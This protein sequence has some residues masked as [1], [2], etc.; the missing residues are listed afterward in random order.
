MTHFELYAIPYRALHYLTNGIPNGLTAEEKE[1]ADNW[2]K[3]EHIA[4]VFD[5]EEHQSDMDALPSFDLGC[6]TYNCS[7]LVAD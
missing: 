4:V 1:K 5:P 6:E 3:A 2:K 7:C